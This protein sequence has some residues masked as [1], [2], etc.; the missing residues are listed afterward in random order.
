MKVTF[1]G[2][3]NAFAQLGRFQSAHWMTIHNS[4]ILFDC[5]NTV[6]SAIKK[7]NLPITQLQTILLSHF[8]GDHLLGLP[9]IFLDRLYLNPVANKLNVY[10]FKGIKGVINTLMETIYPAQSNQIEQVAN[11]HEL[12]VGDEIILPTGIVKTTKANHTDNSLFFKFIPSDHDDTGLPIVA[13][14]GDNELQEEQ[15]SFLSDV[16]ILITECTDW[17]QIGGHHTS[18]NLLKKFLPAIRHM[19]VKK[20]ILVHLGEQIINASAKEFP[21]DVIRTYDGLELNFKELIS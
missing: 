3:G 1:I 14:T 15:L 8:H 10:G 7:F 21:A 9:F 6:L 17:D 16:D 18:W 19:G 12:S 2:T 4:H 11:I 13:Y 5:G 20:I